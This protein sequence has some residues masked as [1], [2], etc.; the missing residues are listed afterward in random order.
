MSDVQ[1][2][3][4]KLNNV[5]ASKITLI[6]IDEMVDVLTVKKKAA[7]LLPGSWIRFTRGKLKGDIGQVGGFF[8]GCCLNGLLCRK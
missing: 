7:V 3:L 4:D 6:P 1:F 8:D 5:Y 2:A